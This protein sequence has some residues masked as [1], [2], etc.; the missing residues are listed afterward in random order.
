MIFPGVIMPNKIGSIAGSD[1]D[2]PS[3]AV[4]LLWIGC[5]ENAAMILRG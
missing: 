3:E 4:V 2:F 1:G 5:M